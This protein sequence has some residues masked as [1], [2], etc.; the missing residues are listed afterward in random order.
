MKKLTLA[1]SVAMALAAGGANA[2]LISVADTT[3]TISGINAF[4]WT[5]DN[6]LADGAGP[7]STD[8]NNQTSFELYSQAALGNYL[9]AGNNV[10]N[11]TGLNVDYELTFQM[12]F[13]ELGYQ[14][15]NPSSTL[16]TGEFSLDTTPGGV[17]FFNVYYDTAMNADTLTGTG[18]G[19]GDLVL[20]G[21]VINQ[22]AT[23]FN[24]A[25]FG[26]SPAF[27]DL[28]RNGANDYPG[29]G[30][31]IGGGSSQLGIG[32]DA[33][34]QDRNFFLSNI[35]SLVVDMFFN[36]SNVTPF[37]QAD[38]AAQVVGI[39]PVYGAGA[40]VPYVTNGG[41]GAPN[42][43]KTFSAINGFQPNGQCFGGA[44]E[45]DFQFQSDSNLSFIA[46]PTP[47]VVAVM[48]LGLIG[49][50]FARRRMTAGK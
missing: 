9:D 12:G 5:P 30:T 47:G 13:S 16:V 44:S 34:N 50:S 24:I 3:G 41:Q 25:L 10:I 43:T 23:T 48:G 21:A 27:T 17:N 20:S 35:S 29:V 28:D 46:T 36:T 38:P 15:T 32:A 42:S 8:F 4:D 31:V 22:G 1:A 45:C 7:L 11:G 2:D 37:N 6:S 14:Y 18:F 19:D 39:N 49:M 33:Q 26:G 40:T